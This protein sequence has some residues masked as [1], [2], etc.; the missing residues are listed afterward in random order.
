MQQWKLWYFS[1]SRMFWNHRLTHVEVCMNTF[2]VERKELLKIQFIH[3]RPWK[4]NIATPTHTDDRGSLGSSERTR[5]DAALDDGRS[6]E[7]AKLQMSCWETDV[8]GGWNGGK[9][10]H[11]TVMDV[12]LHSKECMI[13]FLV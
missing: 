11:F 12:S 13:L 10:S 4:I 7:M 3:V 8:R 1:S 6:E 9:W 2:M 5:C